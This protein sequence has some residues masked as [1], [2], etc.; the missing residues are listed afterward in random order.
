MGVFF[1]ILIGLLMYLNMAFYYYSCSLIPLLPSYS[2]SIFILLASGPSIL[3]LLFSINYGF[4][5]ARD[6]LFY[7]I[8]WMSD[9]S[10]KRL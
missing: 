2:L 8:F 5:V 3:L 1:L 7:C 9:Q 10:F 4:L 6:L